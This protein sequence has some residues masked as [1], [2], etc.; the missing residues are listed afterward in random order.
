M[1][2][3]LILLLSSLTLNGSDN[4]DLNKDQTANAINSKEPVFY[5]CKFGFQLRPVTCT[6]GYDG[7][8]CKGWGRVPFKQEVVDKL[9]HTTFPEASQDNDENLSNAPL[10]SAI[11]EDAYRGRVFDKRDYW[12]GTD[13]QWLSNKDATAQCKEHGFGPGA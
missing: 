7:K 1:K 2:Y 11:A 12:H 13:D 10:L 3:L 4:E 8:Y 9:T 5:A 6:G